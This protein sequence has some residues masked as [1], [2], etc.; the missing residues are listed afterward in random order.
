MNPGAPLWV[1]ALERQGLLKK[2]NNL[3]CYRHFENIYLKTIFHFLPL[4][5]MN[6]FMKNNYSL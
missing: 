3:L 1:K 5:F 6:R 2:R 4:K